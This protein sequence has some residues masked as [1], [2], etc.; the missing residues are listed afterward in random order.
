MGR[1]IFWH[2]LSS[3]RATSDMVRQ[4]LAFVDGKIIL[5]VPWYRGFSVADFDTRFR[6][7][8]HPVTLIFPGLAAELRLIIHNLGAHFGW[9]M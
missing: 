7:P 2:K 3:E 4:S 8:H 6:I 5:M 9:V 1:G